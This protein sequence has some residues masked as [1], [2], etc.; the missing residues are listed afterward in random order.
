[1]NSDQS[2]TPLRLDDLASFAA[3]VDCGGFSAAARRLG[4]SKTQISAALGRLETRLAVR[5]LQR[6]T[7]RLS[8]TDA[9]E[10]VLP[11]AQQ[12]ALAA[13]DALEAATTLMATPRAC[14]GDSLPT[15]PP[16][17]RI[18]NTASTSTA[19]PYG[20]PVTPTATRVCFPASPN[21][22]TNR[23]DAPFSTW[24]WPRKSEVAFTYPVSRRH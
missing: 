17:Q 14:L 12:A 15:S 3:V 23:S 2:A 20:K 19:H 4:V 1:M 22:S 10:A 6:T 18:A 9:G 7:R 5:L 16:C 24:E 21:T 11:Y 13:R 8:L